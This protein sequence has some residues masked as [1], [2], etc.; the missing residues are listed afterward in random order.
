GELRDRLAERLPPYM[1]PEQLTQLPNLPLSANGK[2]DRAAVQTVLGEHLAEHVA[3]FDPPNPG[4]ESAV[5]G[6]WAELLEL[7]AVGRDQNFFTLGGDSLLATRLITRLRAA[8]VAGAELTNLFDH[9]ELAAFARTVRLGEEQAPEQPALR[10]DPEHRHDPFP[11]TDVQRA[12]WIG[13]TDDFAL[14]GVGCHFYTEYDLAGLDLPRLEA[15]WNRLV[16]RH[17]MLRA[18]FLPD[19]TQRILPEVPRL[20]IPVTEARDDPDEA[21][22]GLR[23]A[24]SHQ[25]IDATRWPLFD[26]RAVRYD[27]DRTRLGVSFDNIILDALSTMTVLRE[28]TVLYHDP[29][30]ELPP[31]GPSFRDYVL[32]VKPGPEALRRAEEY[33]S[34]RVAE[35]PPA[36]QLPLALDPARAGRP[37][38][39]RRQVRVPAEQWQAVKDTARRHGL[40][41]STVLATTFAEALGAWSAR[42]DM[43]IN[44]T[45]FDRREVHPDID[46]VLGDFTSLLLV[47]YEPGETWLDSARRLQRRV[48]RDL[49]HSDVSALW[50]MR[51]LARSTGSA[52]VSMPVVFTS[53][54]GVTGE[55]GALTGTLFADPL[56]GVSQTPQVW[57]DHQVVEVDGGLLVNWDAVEELFPPGV[58]DGMFA[59]FAGM[60]ERLSTDD[61]DTAVP[62][63]TP[64][65]QLVTRVGANSTAAPVPDGAL[66][67]RFFER[68]RRDPARVAICPDISYG[69]LAERALR[70]AGFVHE[71][72]VRPGEA[73]AVRLPKGPDQVAAVLGVLAAG[74]LYV[75]IGVD[76]PDLRRERMLRRA[77]VRL[78]ITELPDA[79]PLVGPV[80]VDPGAGAYVI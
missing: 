37:R 49:E 33:W 1:I 20:R 52:D 45:L 67:A 76:Q 42:R 3:H 55:D 4:V 75:P 59:A 60:L 77:D 30:A 43:T 54:L 18:V 53:T 28:L 46:A 15:A 14:G 56:W 32:S 11:P 23:A 10:A 21:L 40:T 78:E 13:R 6:I 80:E 79:A 19:G 64:A 26:V 68:A 51:E 65:E 22:A 8:G 31:V 58:L 48:V 34:A 9:P 25:L 47:A 12:Y 27:E 38:F 24:M 17:E 16:E 61:W 72:G 70:V 50:V 66:H 74:A 57:L 5:A 29:D 69:E 44:L 73:V 62:C 41:P 63:L 2:I 39:T 35:L 36:P 71:Q 7:P